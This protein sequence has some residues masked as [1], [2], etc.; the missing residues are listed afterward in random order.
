MLAETGRLL[1]MTGRLDIISK[2]HAAALKSGASVTIAN[3]GPCYITITVGNEK[4]LGLCFPIP[5]RVPTQKTRIA[6][7]SSYIEVTAQIASAG[8]FPTT[9][10]LTG[11]PL[12]W[13]TTHLALNKQPVLDLLQVKK[14]DW[15]NAHFSKQLSRRE[16]ALRD[17]PSL[18]R[19]P[20]EQARLEFKEGIFAM[21]IQ[22]AGLQ[23]YKANCFAITMPGNSSAIFIARKLRLDIT[24]RTIVL[25]CAVIADK[26]GVEHYQSKQRAGNTMVHIKVSDAAEFR[27][28][29]QALPAWV[30]RCREWSHG[31]KCEYR[32]M[33]GLTIPPSSPTS[34]D[35]PL[36]LCSCGRGVFPADSTLSEA[37]RRYATRAAISPVFWGPFTEEAYL[38]PPDAQGGSGV[39]RGCKGKKTKEGKALMKCGRCRVVEYCSAECQKGDWATHKKV[40]VGKK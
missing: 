29:K 36:I 23:G 4:P 5:I 16:R 22:F 37:V 1:S 12:A 3:P 40:C 35:A 33:S 10:F 25:D 24:T 14:M 20:D 30:E 6:R 34:D 39:C 2:E 7:K 26:A 18:S 19:S 27:M 15:L 31:D 38:P 17:D 32:A 28:W 21:L 13:S 11:T 9:V 8:D